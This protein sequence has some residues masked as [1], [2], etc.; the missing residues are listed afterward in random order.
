MNQILNNIKVILCDTSHQG[1]IGSSA[2]AMKT[3]GITNLILV[4]PKEKPDDHAVALS[5][6]ANDVIENTIIVNELNEAIDDCTI[7][8][9]LTSRKRE[10]N[11]L[12][13]TPKQITKD[14]LTE[15]KKNHKI[16]LVFGSEKFGLSIEQLS[17]CNRLVT[18]PGNPDYFSLN[19]S[20]AVQIMCYEIYS[21]L[22]D[23]VT[24]LKSDIELSTNKD[25]IG[26]L[27]HLEQILT[28]NN[29]Y[30]NKNK[31]R[32]DRRLKYIIDKAMLEREEV[33]LI[34]GILKNIEQH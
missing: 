23:D 12:L 26:I 19:L 7:I 20:Q 29:Y 16:A 8:I 14:I 13:Y 3:M 2:R 5:C 24:H 34:R 1:N 31:E 17:K 27:S 21:N 10:L 18:I 30:K 32:I 4:N 9:G 33:D 15:I 11:T 6:N 25:N 22:N 28:L